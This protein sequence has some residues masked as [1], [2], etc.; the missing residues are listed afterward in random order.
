[1]QSSLAPLRL[2][3]ADALQPRGSNATL[4]SVGTLCGGFERFVAAPLQPCRL[5][6]MVHTVRSCSRSF[7]H[8]FQQLL[9]SQI[10]IPAA[11]IDRAKRGCPRHQGNGSV[12]IP[13]NTVMLDAA[14][15]ALSA[16]GRALPV[17]GGP[18]AREYLEYAVQVHCMQS[19]KGVS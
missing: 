1:M 11:I 12:E 7:R 18:E 6:A 5:Y 3:L 4:A 14:P 19:P 8:S 9:S 17:I 16:K 10:G 15:A 13:C 2:M